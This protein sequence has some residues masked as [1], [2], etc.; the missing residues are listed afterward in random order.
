METALGNYFY[1]ELEKIKINTFLA[2]GNYLLDNFLDLWAQRILTS[3]HPPYKLGNSSYMGLIVD[4]RPTRLLR[5]T[6]L[7]TILMGRLKMHIRL[8]T[9]HDS[10]TKMKKLFSDIGDWISI[11]LIN[12][13]TTTS[14]DKRT[15]NKLLKDRKFWAELP[16]ENLLVFQA[17]SLLIEPMD[18]TM[19]SYDYVASLWSRNIYTTSFLTYT[20]DLESEKVPFWV[21]TINNKVLDD[22][23]IIGNGGLSIR[24]RSAMESIC[25]SIPSY[26]DEA[27]DIYFSRCLLANDANLPP[28]GIARRFSIESEYFP[29][30]G[31]HASHLYLSGEQQAAIYERHFKN[32]IALITA[33]TGV[34][35]HPVRVNDKPD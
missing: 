31:A 14:I 19:F 15:Y 16:T 3:R 34:A 8:I 26:D 24:N 12:D 33:S 7:N 21:T 28:L 1:R 10:F 5:F 9:S 25:E 32:L 27:E 22:N 23:L 13:E 4:D 17:D 2:H 35:F 30:I 18:Y 20:N 29:S 11:E 6:V